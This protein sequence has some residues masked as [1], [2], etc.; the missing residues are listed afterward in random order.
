M[1][2]ELNGNYVSIKNK[3]WTIAFDVTDMTTSNQK[4]QNMWHMRLFAKA[5]YM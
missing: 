3:A 2:E 4:Q 1:M 5:H